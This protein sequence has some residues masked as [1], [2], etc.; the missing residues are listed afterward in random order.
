MAMK[1]L[2]LLLV[3]TLALAPPS[4]SMSENAYV[5]V[6]PDGF[7]PDADTALKIS[8]VILVRIFGQAQIDVERPLTVTLENGVW[9]VKGTLPPKALG[10]IAELHISKNDGAILFLSHGK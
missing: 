2:V 3:A 5:R 10:G 6:P 1:H 8:E 7:V 4:T 9:I